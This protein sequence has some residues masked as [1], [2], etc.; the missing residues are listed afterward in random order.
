MKADLSLHSGRLAERWQ[1]MTLR[2]QLGNIGSEVGRALRAHAQGDAGRLQKALDRALELFDVTLAD[3]RHRGRRR[4]ICRAREVFLDFLV[5]DNEYAATAEG[6]DAY[7]LQFGVAARLG[8][9][10]RS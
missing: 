9:N 6:L 10:S 2:E 7:Y 5:G 1:R 8:R 3:S 4:E